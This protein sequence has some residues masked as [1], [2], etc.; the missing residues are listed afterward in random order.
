MGGGS[1]GGSARSGLCAA[2]PPL[3]HAR[4]IHKGACN[5]GY[6]WPSEPLGWDVA[7]MTDI[8]DEYAGMGRCG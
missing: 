5:Y 3:P 1:G 4:S 2:A 7:A 6:I 8:H